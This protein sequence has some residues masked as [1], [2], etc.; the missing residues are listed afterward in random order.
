MG[1][2]DPAEFERWR[3]ADPRHA[4]AF[5]RAAAVWSDLSRAGRGMAPPAPVRRPSR[6]RFLE[7][8][9]IG[10]V[11]LLG[12]G[13]ATRAFARQSLVTDVGEHRNRTLADGSTLTL[14]TDTK[15]FWRL[16]GSGGA[17]WLE[18]GE[19]SLA[20]GTA[21][22]KLKT[23]NSLI[24]LAPHGHYNARLRGP[25]LDLTVLRG[26]ASAS[27]LDSMGGAPVEALPAQSLSLTAAG[28]LMRGAT[29]LELES[30]EAWRRGEIVFDDEPLAAAVD[31][32]NRYLVRKLI[33][34]D[35][36]IA[37]VR[38][39]GRFTS[40][41]PADFLKALSASLGVRATP[42]AKG[43]ILTGAK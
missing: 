19:V 6:R 11:A 18:R 40:A 33:I 26:R 16:S 4:I 21:A 39:G 3:D 41:D 15:V 29:P 23:P 43:V 2:A 20:L 9:G 17:L 7:A 27:P 8:A 32:Y 5:A 38:V 36:Q 24:E 12:G 37:R 14:N 13:V 28:P 35:P 10:A 34:V 31:E 22:F 30:A 1:T 25:V 42:H